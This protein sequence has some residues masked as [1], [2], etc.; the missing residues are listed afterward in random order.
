M[1]VTVA[2]D[3]DIGDQDIWDMVFANPQLKPRVFFKR[4][5][6]RE[7]KWRN[8]VGATSID[9]KTGLE[10]GVSG[11]EQLYDETLRPRMRF[12]RFLHGE[13]RLIGDK[14][15]ADGFNVILQEE[16]P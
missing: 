12:C 13:E 1:S 10:I 4:V 16:M 11:L 6:T 3:L 5:T 2:H 14:E 15:R 7:P 8:I 9:P